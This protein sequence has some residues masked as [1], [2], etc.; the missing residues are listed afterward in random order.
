MRKKHETT[1]N[2]Q[3]VW[4]KEPNQIDIEEKQNITNES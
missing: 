4:K 1:L 3:V 2:G